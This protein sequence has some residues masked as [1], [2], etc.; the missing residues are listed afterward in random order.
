MDL[1]AKVWEVMELC[2]ACNTLT[3]MQLQ[4]DELD[5]ES[6]CSALTLA[7]HVH[8]S[9][10]KVHRAALNQAKAFQKCWVVSD[11]CFWGGCSILR[12]SHLAQA[13]P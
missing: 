8:S 7:N 5:G 10:Q 3:L 9:P 1:R 2:D 11:K 4:S 13:R 6:I 12:A